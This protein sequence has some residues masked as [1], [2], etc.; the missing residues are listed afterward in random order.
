M[1]PSPRDP[2]GPPKALLLDL[3]NVTVRLRFDLFF[4]GLKAACPGRAPGELRSLLQDPATGH[5]DFERGLLDGPAWHALL[6]ER[7][8]LALGYEDWLELWNN[9]F[10]PNVPM[11]RLIADLRGQVRFWG[12]SNTNAEHLRHLKRAF[13]VLDAFEGITASCEVG[14]RKP[15]PAIYAAAQRSLGLAGRD[16]LYLDDIADYVRAGEASGLRVF[17]YTFN[18]A[19]LRQSLRSMGLQ[20][21]DSGAPGRADGDTL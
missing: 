21:P 16:I 14:A 3:G 1:K 9:W 19:Q 8:G 12:L 13:P 20:A 5:D 17:H 7:M 15:E 10:E 18:D 2:E 11:E 4:E 6:Q